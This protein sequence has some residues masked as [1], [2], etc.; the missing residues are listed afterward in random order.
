MSAGAPIPLRNLQ[1]RLEHLER[2]LIETRQQ[3]ASVQARQA[4]LTQGEQLRFVKTGKYE[5]EYPSGTGDPVGN[6][7]PIRFCDA[8]LGTS[9]FYGA[10]SPTFPPRSA[11]KQAYACAF[12]KRFI[13][14]DQDCL[15]V[16]LN[17][18]WWILAGPGQFYFGRLNAEVSQGG[19]ATMQLLNWN[20]TKL[21]DTD[22]DLA[23]YDY[24]LNAG[25][26]PLE[27]KTKVL[28]QLIYPGRYYITAAGCDVDSNADEL[29]Q[30]ESSWLTSM[31]QP[32]LAGLDAGSQSPAVQLPAVTQ[33][34]LP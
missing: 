6:T 17:E 13:L 5:G 3:L 34:P 21:I 4:L 29:Y 1:H 18:H 9:W 28:A 23:V 2:D 27:P 32:F 12:D 30:A 10:H 25:D 26:D 16:L 8:D 22:F 15:A 31:A 7:F 19:G 24:F 33:P 14:P 11:T 20:G